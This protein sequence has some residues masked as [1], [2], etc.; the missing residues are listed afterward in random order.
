ME[1]SGITEM[2]C[3]GHFIGARE[4]GWRRH[5]QIVGSKANYKV[6]SVG[7]YRPSGGEMQA[8]GFGESYY[9][10]AVFRLGSKPTEESDGCGCLE[11]LNW[12]DIEM[13]RYKSALAAW[14]GHEDMVRKYA[15]IADGVSE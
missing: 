9:E 14:E 10:T 15:K 7:D 4:C 2:G 1:V 8:L 3:C 11:T 5:T 13:V 6:S 12:Q